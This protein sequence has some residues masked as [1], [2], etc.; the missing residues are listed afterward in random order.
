MRS[1][2]FAKRELFGRADW[3]RLEAPV[4]SLL[5][6]FNCR[7]LTSFKFLTDSAQY[8]GLCVGWRAKLERID[9]KAPQRPKTGAAWPRGL[10]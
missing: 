6:T 1:P 8:Y 5:W 10:E 2:H 3:L 4:R 9:F 7:L